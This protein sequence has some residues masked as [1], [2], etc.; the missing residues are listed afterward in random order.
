MHHRPLVDPVEAVAQPVKRFLGKLPGEGGQFR[1]VHLAA[2]PGVILGIEPPVGGVVDL[3]VAVEGVRPIRFPA[4][5]CR[6]D[7]Q[8]GRIRLLRLRVFR[9]RSSLANLQRRDWNAANL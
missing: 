7:E 8:S 9:S 4:A 2:Q 1:H 5:Q 3:D 6:G